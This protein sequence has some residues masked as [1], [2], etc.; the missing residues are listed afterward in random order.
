MAFKLIMTMTITMIVLFGLLFGIVAA[1]G[2]YYGLSW[3][4]I[5]ALAGIIVFFQWLV[6]PRIIWWTTNMR[7]LKRGEME[8]LQDSVK[9]I[10]RKNKVPFPKM[11]LAR[12]GAPNAFVFGRTPNS[13]T[14]VVTTG[15]LK[16]LNKDEVRA[17]IAHEV[18]HIK[19]RDMIVMTAI[20]VIPVIAYY[21]SRFTIFAPRSSNRKKSGSAMI[22]GL[23]AFLVYAISNLLVLYLSRLREYYSDRFAGQNVNPKL[24]ASA[25]VKITYGLSMSKEENSS[26]VRSFYIADPLTA[27]N[28][29]SMLSEKGDD[30]GLDESEIKSSMEWEKKNILMRAGEIFRTHPLTYKRV[31]ALMKMRGSQ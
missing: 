17:V 21:I 3:I 13:A 26:S 7:H 28:D 24:L 9:D 10:C 14:L 20:S 8:W 15:L 16:S 18:G 31:E 19:H 30:I 12:T 25:L 27:R 2:Y 1:F 22:V 5:A 4:W 6:G 23:V 11:A 29:M